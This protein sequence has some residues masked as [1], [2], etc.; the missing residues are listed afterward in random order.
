MKL[1]Q[2]YDIGRI[3]RIHFCPGL[4]TPITSAASKWV[5]NNGVSLH[6]LRADWEIVDDVFSL[7]YSKGIWFTKSKVGTGN[8]QFTNINFDSVGIG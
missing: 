3:K 8:G 6:L 1:D 7:G 2:I 4:W 5:Q